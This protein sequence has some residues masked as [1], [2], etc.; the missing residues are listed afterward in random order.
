MGMIVVYSIEYVNRYVYFCWYSNIVMI[1]SKSFCQKR[2]YIY[3]Y[4]LVDVHVR[5]YQPTSVSYQ[6]RLDCSAV[7]QNIKTNKTKCT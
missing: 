7:I 5:I 4:F 1:F 6:I 3:S 2:F